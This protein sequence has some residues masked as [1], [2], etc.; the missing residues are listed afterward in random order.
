MVFTARLAQANLVDKTEFNTKLTSFN[1]RL[2]SNKTKHLVTENELKRIKTF[3]LRY[4]TGKHF[5]V[6]MFFKIYFFIKKYR[7][8][9]RKCY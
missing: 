8:D 7:K 6:T 5:L 9:I 4:F 3:D 1:K 2:N